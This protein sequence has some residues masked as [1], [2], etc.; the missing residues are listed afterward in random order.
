MC[1]GNGFALKGSHLRLYKS[2]KGTKI[3]MMPTDMGYFGT[4]GS[5]MR[6]GFGLQ[7]T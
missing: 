1:G 7:P 6:L 3:S 5:G 4:C 2:S